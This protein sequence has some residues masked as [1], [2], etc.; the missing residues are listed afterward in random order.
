MSGA[1]SPPNEALFDQNLSFKLYRQLADLFPDSSQVRLAG[2]DKAD[3]HAVW[4]YARTHDFVLVSL[5]ADFAEMATLLGT[6]PKVIWLR[7]GNQSTADIESILR[8]HAE[9]IAAFE[10]DAVACLEIY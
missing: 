5:D 3:D 7:C 8:N 2:L 10:N 4:E 9:A 1:C 6:P